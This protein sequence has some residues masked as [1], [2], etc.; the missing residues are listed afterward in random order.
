MSGGQPSARSSRG[1][2]PDRARTFGLPR[3]CWARR[4]VLRWRRSATAPLS[5]GF[6]FFQAEDGIRDLTET[7]VQTC[8]LPICVWREETHKQTKCLSWLRILPS[9]RLHHIGL[10]I[11][12]DFPKGKET[13]SD[14]TG[15]AKICKPVLKE[16]R[17]SVV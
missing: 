15:S 12:P 14:S 17:K 9:K 5:G 13:Y 1:T 11:Y 8:A 10:R 2:C 7:G 16:D 3:S 4:Q 6:F